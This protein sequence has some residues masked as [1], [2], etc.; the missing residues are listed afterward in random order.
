M[1]PSVELGKTIND[2]L[3][4]IREVDQALDEVAG[5]LEVNN[6][7][8]GRFYLLPKIHKGLS[9]VKG[10]PVISNCG[11]STNNV[12]EYLDYHLNPL[13]SQSRSYVKDTNNFLSNIG[14]IGTIPEGAILC[15][16]DVVGLYPSIPHREGLEAIREALDRRENPSV[17]TE[18]LAGLASLALENNYF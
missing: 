9:N 8:L 10:R 17:A 6:P 2:K 13:V 1:D 11:T 18:I 12:S 7:R 16:V 15:T 4:E 3:K 14:N 5:Y